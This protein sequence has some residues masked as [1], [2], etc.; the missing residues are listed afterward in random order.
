MTEARKKTDQ[1][2]DGIIAAGVW[3]LAFM[4]PPLIAPPKGDVYMGEPFL[5]I[6]LAIVLFIYVVRH[7]R[8]ATAGDNIQ[9]GDLVAKV[10]APLVIFLLASWLSFA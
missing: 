4:A 3:I 10:I 7:F 8:N 5:G 6:P 1:I 2:L 9:V